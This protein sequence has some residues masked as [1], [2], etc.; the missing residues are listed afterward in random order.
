LCLLLTLCLALPLP[1]AAR[2]TG[3]NPI[4]RA[5]IE[6]LFA[7]KKENNQLQSNLAR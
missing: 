7:S 2:R 4:N 5:G 3:E 1:S 6:T